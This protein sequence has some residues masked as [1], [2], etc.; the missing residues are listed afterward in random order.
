MRLCVHVLY[1]YVYI[2]VY[3]SYDDVAVGVL[4]E[5]KSIVNPLRW[6]SSKNHILSSAYLTESHRIFSSQ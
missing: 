6:D 4:A 1:V 2:L 3:T 5:R